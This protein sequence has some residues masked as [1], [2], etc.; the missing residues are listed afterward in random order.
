[1]KNVKVQKKIG[2]NPLNGFALISV[3]LLLGVLILM[4]SA[5]FSLM[6]FES[7][8]SSSQVSTLQT[9]YSAEAGINE[10]I[11]KLRNDSD[12]NDEFLNG[13]IDRQLSQTNII[14]ENGSYEV[15]ILGTAEGEAGVVSTGKHQSRGTTAQRIVK[16]QIIQATNPVPLEDAATYSNIDTNINLSYVTLGNGNMF[17]NDDID[18]FAWSRADIN[19]GNAMAVNE[20]HFYFG[21]ELNASGGCWSSNCPSECAVCNPEPDSISMPMLDF[22]S[23]DE[24]SYKSVATAIYTEKEFLDLLK[25][26][27]HNDPLILNDDVTYVEGDVRVKK[28]QKLIVNGILVADGNIVVGEW[29]G[30]GNWE[31]G[32]EVNHEVG[33]GSGLIS[34]GSIEYRARPWIGDTRIDGILY[35]SDRVTIR[36]LGSTGEGFEITGAIIAREIDFLDFLG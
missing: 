9:Y 21:S 35:A 32:I 2:N 26:S 8:I 30:G 19:N 7:K 18:L 27:K 33:R 17:S 15:T 11:F 5:F 25:N 4:S 22:D 29:K 14:T 23:E 24:N 1:M 20:I 34:K 6:K 10:M 13:T 28:G 31:T 12:W 36:H 16:T 3:I